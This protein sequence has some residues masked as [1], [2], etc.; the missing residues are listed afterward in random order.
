MNSAHYR[1]ASATERRSA[2]ANGLPSR[3]NSTRFADYE[4]PQVQENGS[5]VLTEHGFDN[6]DELNPKSVKYA[7][8]V[9]NC[10]ERLEHLSAMQ[11]Q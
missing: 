11:A 3:V 4:R 7:Q 10:E 6:G 5:P 1:S 8:R 2:H 9:E